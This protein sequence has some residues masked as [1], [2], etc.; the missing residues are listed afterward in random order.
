[1]TTEMRSSGHEM[2]VAGDLALGACVGMAA[3]A[4]PAPVA[5]MGRFQPDG[6]QSPAF[7]GWIKSVVTPESQFMLHQR[8]PPVLFDLR[9]DTPQ[10]RNLADRPDRAK[11]VARFDAYLRGI[12]ANEIDPYALEP[13]RVLECAPEDGW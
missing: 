4:W 7:S 10:L 12:G 13:D 2:N 1:M 6:E 5:E 8:L 9:T 3:A 11:I